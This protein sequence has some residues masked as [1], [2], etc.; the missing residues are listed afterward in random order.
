M[1]EVDFLQSFK[2][3]FFFILFCLVLFSSGAPS[4]ASQTHE[5][6]VFIMRT[7]RPVCSETDSAGSNRR[8]EAPWSEPVRRSASEPETA[9]LSLPQSSR[10]VEDCHPA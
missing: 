3:E 10:R 2:Q 9:S 8:V 1:T 7:E 6:K 5:L 4:T